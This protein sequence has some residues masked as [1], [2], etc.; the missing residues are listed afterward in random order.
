MGIRRRPQMEKRLSQAIQRYHDHGPLLVVEL[1]DEV[2]RLREQVS[3]LKSHVAQQDSL[4]LA[5]EAPKKAILAR[6]GAEL[7]AALKAS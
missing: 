5:E 3:R 6:R 1:E 7:V 2:E 4:G